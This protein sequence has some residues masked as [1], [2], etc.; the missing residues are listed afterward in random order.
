[1]RIQ[2]GQE[3]ERLDQRLLELA[4]QVAIVRRSLAGAGPDSGLQDPLDD[5]V[6]ELTDF[7]ADTLSDVTDR[8]GR[9]NDIL[10]ELRHQALA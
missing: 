4:R 7:V 5:H 3:M 9:F 2:N 10:V 8:L 6:R 1:M